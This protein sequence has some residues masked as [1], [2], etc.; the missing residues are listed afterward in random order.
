MDLVFSPEHA[1]GHVDPDETTRYIHDNKELIE[2]ARRVDA[3]NDAWLG[4]FSTADSASGEQ[5]QRILDEAARVRDNA[6][7]MIVVGIGGS[8]RGAMAAIQALRRSL[9][10]PT[11]VVFAGDTLSASGLRDALE[12]VKSESVVLNVVAKDFNTVEPG[13]AFR[14]LREAMIRKYGAAYNG[15]IVVTGS[16]GPGQL[17]ELAD[18]HGYRFLGFPQS[19]GGRFS[20]L[21]T[22][23]L[24]PMA[25][26]GIDVLEVLDGARVA[27]L[28]LKTTDVHSNPAVLYAVY[29]NL[30]FSK[31]FGVESLVVFEPDL[32]PLARWW[33]QLFAE[34]EGKSPRAVFPTFFSYS[35][36]LH[37]VGQYV[38]QGRRCITETYLGLFHKNPG[39]TIHGSEQVRDGFDYLDG[40]PF[41]DLNRAVYAAAL[42]AHARDG[43]PCLEISSSSIGGR[44]LGELFYFFM[45]SCRVSATLLGVDPFTQDGVEGYK[46]NMYRILGKN[47]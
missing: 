41:D 36:D 18:R 29:R 28:A 46:K 43:V 40:R 30:L 14:V 4:W 44:I 8:N 11:R 9:R 1:R 38:Q 37:A 42:E 27:E 22:V 33:I 31:G 5:L 10:S 7:T 20:V 21:S 19:I 23:A 26:A 2:R 16:F 13:I 47:G 25:V 35:E 32:A 24:F 15:R 17:F 12:I 6:G 45:F 34:S 3:G 39:F